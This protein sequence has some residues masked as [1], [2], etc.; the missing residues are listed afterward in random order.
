MISVQDFNQRVL[1][2]GLA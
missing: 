1:Y 2:G